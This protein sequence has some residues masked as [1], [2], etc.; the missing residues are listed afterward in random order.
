MNF[1]EWV[2]IISLSLIALSILSYIAVIFIKL[3]RENKVAYIKNDLASIVNMLDD[4]FSP[5]DTLGVEAVRDLLVHVHTGYM[6]SLVNFELNNQN[7][8]EPAP[9]SRD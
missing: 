4:K 8:K 6:F 1:L 3:H 9:P 2:G 5:E 7:D